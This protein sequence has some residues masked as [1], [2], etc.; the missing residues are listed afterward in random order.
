MA[1]GGGSSTS[2]KKGDVNGDGEITIDDLAKIKLHLIDKEVLTGRNFKAADINNDGEITIDD[3][4]KIRL[5]LIGLI[6]L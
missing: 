6:K 2:V 1:G 5:H 4:A 3:L